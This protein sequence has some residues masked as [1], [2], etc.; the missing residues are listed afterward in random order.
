MNQE[1]KNRQESF[2]EQLSLSTKTFNNYRFALNSCFLRE[3]IKEEFDVLG[4]FEID[5]IEDLW[6]L[7]TKVNLHPK[8]I[9]SHRAYS[10]AIMKYIRF[11]NNG[12][13]YG[14]RIDYNKPKGNIMQK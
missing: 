5:K 8:N 10:A 3:I 7:Y 9:R 1:A 12:K 6:A 14:R 13:K 4:I 2:F 11:L